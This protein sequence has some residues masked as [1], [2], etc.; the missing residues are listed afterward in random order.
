MHD[1]HLPFPPGFIPWH[2]SVFR[3]DGVYYLLC[4]GYDD[5]RLFIARSP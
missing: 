3:G 2:L 4:N 5:A 1:V